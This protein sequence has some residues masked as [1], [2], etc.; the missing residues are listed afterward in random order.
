MQYCTVDLSA[1]YMDILKDRLYCDA[2]NGPRRRSAQAAMF[3]MADGLARFMAPLLVF[4]GDEIYESLHK[5][6]P[7]AVHERE[8]PARVSPDLAVLDIWKPLLT[9][10]DTVLK[11]LETSRAAKTIASSL[12]ADLVLTGSAAVLAPLRAHAALPAPFPG[13][14][15]NLFI[16][17]AVSLEEAPGQPEL[18][19]RVRRAEG[20]KCSRCWTYSTAARTLEPSDPR[21]LCS[22]CVDVVQQGAWS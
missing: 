13:N 9:A 15:A 10:R 4:T 21:L 19:V 6:E 14:L 18:S 2:A 20:R 3:R 12:E 1:F 17:S 22:R 16:V 5:S 7:G 11:T 8:F